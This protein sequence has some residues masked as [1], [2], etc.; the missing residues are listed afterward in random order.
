VCQRGQQTKRA[1]DREDSDDEGQPGR[2]KTSEHQQQKQEDHR[3][4]E[5]FTQGEVVIDLFGDL[6]IAY[7]L[8]THLDIQR[9]AAGIAEGLDEVLC[10]LIDIKL[11]SLDVGQ[12]QRPGAVTAAQ[13]LRRTGTPVRHQ[14]IDTRSGGELLG[15]RP[16]GGDSIRIVDG[17]A[18]GVGRKDHDVRLAGV[19]SLRQQ[20]CGMF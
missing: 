17:S 9:A 12:D 6:Q 1:D 18:A 5:R 11:I 7:R 15:D 13:Q 3:H 14:R 19:E 4:S 10:Y 20:S 8:A 16:P 2:D